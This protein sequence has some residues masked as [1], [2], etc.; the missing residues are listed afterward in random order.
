M[1]SS[2]D[3]VE[4]ELS[5]PTGIALLLNL[6]D[7]F[8][9]P[10]KYS[11]NSYGVGIGSLKLPYPN[12]VRVLEIDSIEQNLKD[13]KIS[14]R[15][16]EI[17]I[18]EALID[19]QTSEEIAN[20]LEIFRKKGAYDV[21]CQT[22]NMKKNRTG[23]SIQVILPVEK[24]E[25]FRELWFQYSNTIGLR[26]RK[27]FRW[28]L[29]R[30][31]GECLTTFGIIKFKQTMKPNVTISMK[32]E[33]D[34]ILRLQIENNKTAQEVRNIIKGSCREFKAFEDWK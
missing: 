25:Y 18:Q 29:L 12:L 21:S 17:S 1:I 31:R 34:E 16:E 20:L 15:Y 9:I 14:P 5:T 10:Y 11:I 30:R 7:S 4:G 26:E 13:H 33:N 3:S 27:Q 23:F 6:V 24:Q 19:D 2:I 32:P 22:I 8:K 28:V